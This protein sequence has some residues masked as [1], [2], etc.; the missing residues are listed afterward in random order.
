MADTT[1]SENIFLRSV[2]LKWRCKIGSQSA[3]VQAMTK[4]LDPR[5]FGVFGQQIGVT[6][7][8]KPGD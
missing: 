8:S 7:V 4:F 3:A 2:M 6:G 5:A 1:D